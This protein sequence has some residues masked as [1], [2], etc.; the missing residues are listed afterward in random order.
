MFAHSQAYPA[1]DLCA[2]LSREHSHFTRSRQSTSRRHVAVLTSLCLQLKLAGDIAQLESV[3]HAVLPKRKSDAFQV[4][5]LSFPLGRFLDLCFRS[6][7]HW[8]VCLR[9]RVAETQIGCFPGGRFTPLAT[10]RFRLP[11]SALWVC[12]ALLLLLCALLVR[13][14]C[15]SRM[16]DSE[17]MLF[18]VVC[19]GPGSAQGSRF[20]LQRYDQCDGHLIAFVGMR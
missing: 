1:S 17:H 15:N 16:C 18:L 9:C 13:P 12:R 14:R 20:R 11:Q 2:P 7:L 5:C 19:S 6:L 3:L 10:S 8:V 4:L